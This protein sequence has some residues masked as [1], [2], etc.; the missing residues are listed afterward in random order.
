[1]KSYERIYKIKKRDLSKPLAILVPDYKWLEDNTSLTSEQVK[2]LKKYE[3]PFTILTDCDHLKIWINYVDEDNN[4]FINRDIYERFAFRVV[5][6][7]TEKR[8]VKEN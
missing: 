6:N 2:F 3:K 5:N 4:E 8:L 1:V 7:D